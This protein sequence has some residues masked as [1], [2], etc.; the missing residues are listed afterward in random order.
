MSAEAV[1]NLRFRVIYEDAVEAPL[2][3]LHEQEKQRIADTA[4]EQARANDA[5]VK[6][7]Y[8]H[9]AAD[10]Q[11]A[12]AKKK[13]IVDAAR[14]QA[15]SDADYERAIKKHLAAEQQLADAKKRAADQAQREQER[16]AQQRIRETKAIEAAEA[17][18]FQAHIRAI[19]QQ[20]R[21]ADIASKSRIREIE[22]ET[23][24]KMQQWG[25]EDARTIKAMRAQT[26]QAQEFRK[27]STAK[28]DATH[29]SREAIDSEIGSVQALG[30]AFMSLM[31]VQRVADVIRQ[32]MQ[33]VGQSI[34]EARGYIQQLVTEM[35]AA[36]TAARELAA[37]R[38]QSATGGFTAQLAREAAAAGVDVEQYHQFSTAYE[39][40]TGQYT[41]TSKEEETPAQLAAKGQKINKGQA[42]QLQ[43]Q[44]AGYAMGARGLS[45]EDSAQLLG[46]IISKSKAGAS[47]EDIMSDYAKL[48]KVAE[49][50]PGRTSPMLSQI[51]EIGMENVGPQGDMKNVL[52][53]GYLTRIMAQRNPAEAATYGRA[54]MRGLRQIRMNPMQMSELGI[55]KGMDLNQQLLAVDNAVKQHV[56]AGGD[57]GQF[58]S[59]YFQDIREWGGISTAINEGIRGGGFQRAQQEAASVNAETARQATIAYQ[60]GQEGRAARD[61]SEVLAIQRESASKYAELRHIEMESR[62]AVLVGGELEVP[63]NMVE[64]FLTQGYG[65]IL[66]QGSRQEQEERAETGRMIQERLMR[67]PE[68]WKYLESKGVRYSAITGEPSQLFGRE[69]P[70]H[71][72][73]EAANEL[74]RIR[75]LQEQQ[76]Q[77]PRPPMVAQP[78]NPPGRQGG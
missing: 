68:G 13:A 54:L 56:A 60:Q 71:E 69:T 3:R 72:L 48:M 9:L 35:E 45:A 70:R 15:K 38:G 49:L 75:Q 67:S 43:K 58:L 1:R 66:G 42:L 41:S 64:S 14:E 57:E 23:R 30:Q 4:K 8:K 18:A 6:A 27:A 51:T 11:V 21:A 65:A 10:R 76:H 46:L 37:L 25:R 26:Q 2:R 53:A 63:E 19:D 61:R 74:K 32:G 16:N 50:A 47:N 28:L 31:A 33:A 73:M 39:A 55:Q 17:R 59:K 78:P 29:K 44:V 40:Y 77:G 12:D 7:I 20:S 5:Y 52:Q 22:S 34:Q 62:K 24:E 36:R